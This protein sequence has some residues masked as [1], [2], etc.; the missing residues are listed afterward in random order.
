MSKRDAD[1]RAEN[2]SR[3]DRLW[4]P[5]FI[6]LTALTFCGFL[7]SQGLNSGTSVYLSLTG[8]G[9]TLAGVLGA[10]FSF[11]AGFTRLIAGPG[12]DR[13]GRSRF[14]VCGLAI[15][16]VATILP[17]FTLGPV[18]LTCCRAAQGVGFSMATTAA[19]TAAADV[20][21]VSRLGEGIG[22]YGLGQ[23]LAMSIGPAFALWLVS[24]DPAE[25]IFFGLAAV[26]AIGL[27]FSFTIRYERHPQSL[28]AG[29]AYR[30]RIEQGRAPGAE[31]GREALGLRRL[32][33]PRALAGAI[34]MCVLSPVYGYAIF[35][36]GLFGTTLGVGNA[37]LF[38]TFSALVMLV[39]R[40]LSGTF[41]DRVRPLFILLVAVAGGMVVFSIQLLI[42]GWAPSPATSALY[43]LSGGFYGVFIG[44][45]QPL[46]Q[47]VAVKNTPPERWGAANAL[48]LLALDVGC[49]VGAAALGAVNDR[50]GFGATLVIVLCFLMAGLA[51]AAKTYPRPERR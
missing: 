51:T 40:A 42:A 27:A 45:S 50:L 4:T 20:L 46:N 3:S 7:V 24:T 19:A 21:P 15:L 36:S 29:S 5:V 25:N 47:S 6:C 37:G 30:R 22:Y 32:F 16:V 33:E 39:L 48:V 18:V 35:F 13:Y 11:G 2:G 41:M 8:M 10:L 9:S 28:P 31:A 12:A 26:A 38:F 44:L 1:E 34:P 17:A 49:G 43:Y 23:A 14:I